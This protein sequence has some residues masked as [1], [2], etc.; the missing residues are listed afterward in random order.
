V[1][2][3]PVLPMSEAADHPHIKARNT[4]VEVN[5]IVQPAPAPRFSRTPGSVSRA[6]PERGQG[7]AAALADWGFD[8]AAVAQFRA[9]G[10]L[11][12]ED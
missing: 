12:R 7:G 2:F 4:I 6:A 1:C 10:A 8:T 9:E 5:G 11:M 3:A